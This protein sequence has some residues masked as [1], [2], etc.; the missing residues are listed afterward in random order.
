MRAT[1]SMLMRLSPARFLSAS[2]CE[3]HEGYRQ[4]LACCHPPGLVLL[5]KHELLHREAAADRD[6]HAT[7]GLE[8]L[9]ER[10]RD[11]ARS[12]GDDDAVKGCRLGPTVIAVARAGFDVPVQP[13]KAFPSTL[14]KVRY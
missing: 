12:R 3:R 13:G 11:V 2:T 5:D 14:G 8:L 9:D 7:A 4:E 1:A 10:W 6:C